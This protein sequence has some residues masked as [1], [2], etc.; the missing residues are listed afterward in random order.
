MPDPQTTQMYCL[1]DRL[2]Y[3]V[4]G[5]MDDRAD[6]YPPARGPVPDG[7]RRSDRGLWTALEPEGARVPGQGWKIHVSAVPEQAG[8]TL[9]T[10]AAACLARRTP[11]KFLRSPQALRVLNATHTPRQNSGKFITLYPAD[12]AEFA[13]LVEELSAALAGRPGPYILTDLRIGDGP[14][15][16]RYG[17]FRAMHCPGPDGAPVPALLGPDGRPRPDDRAPVFTVPDWITPPEVLVPHLAALESATVDGLP[18]R[19]VRALHFTNAGG[20][21]L[22]EHLRTGHR[23]VLREARPH[24]GLDRTGADAV[25]RLRREYQA[26]RRLDG[27]DCVPAVLGLRTM[28]EHH[29]LVEEYIE[30]EPLLHAAIT[31]TPLVRRDCTEQDLAAYGGWVREV[32]E[33]VGRALDRVH[34][35]GLAFGDLHPGNIILRPDGSV[36]L[37]DFEYAAEVSDSA[38]PRAAAAGFTVPRGVTGAAADHHQLEALR[39]MLLLPMAELTELHPGKRATLERLARARFP[40]GGGPARPGA[41]AAGDG[42]GDRDGDERT[43]RRLFGIPAAD[44][45]WLDAGDPPARPDW[46][47]VRRLLTAGLHAAATPERDDRLFPGAPEVFAQGGHTLAHGAAG[48]LLALHRSGED[49]PP[50]YADW[51]AAAAG[52]ADPAAGGGLLGGPYGTASVLYDLGRRAEALE[53]LHRAR[54]APPP[55]GAG[56]AGGTAGAALTLLRFARLTGDTELYDDAARTAEAL[57]AEALTAEALAAA[58]P[59][60]DVPVGLLHGAAGAALLNLRLY[61]LTGERD[62]LRAA[63]RLIARDLAGC[64]T[65]EDGAAYVQRDGYRHLPY[66]GEGSGGIALVARECLAETG[67]DPGLSAFLAGTRLACG[68]ATVREPGLMQGRAGLAAVLRAL[69]GDEREVTAQAA[70]L[71]WHAVHR[72]GTLLI[73]GTRLLR[74]SADLATG[75]AGVLLALHCVVDRPPGGLLGALVPD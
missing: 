33:R 44:P 71:A 46:P 21:Y 45:G 3:E 73:P 5:R 35:R 10:V 70:R 43:V 14:V 6:R 39:L 67:D 56:L 68:L 42:E 36:V 31:R 69:D 13:K 53:L 72:D 54:Q 15:Y 60:G 61:R 51:L 40:G 38:A 12:D 66:V 24:S 37:V 62:R 64:V 65:R 57:T 1:A 63:R 58:A 2:Y 41:R 52:R 23:V 20:I 32:T 49:V 47:A 7:W 27:L 11:F 26:L 22:A 50:E 55:R 34:G 59:A 9:A 17:A 30:G 48:V 75:A 29:Y 28:W 74:F 18:Y 19:I 16:V 25:A 4:P 8:D